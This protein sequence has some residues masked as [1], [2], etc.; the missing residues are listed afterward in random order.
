[1]EAT[2]IG[3]FA[4]CHR[5]QGFPFVLRLSPRAKKMEKT[6]SVSDRG[7]WY[8]KVVTNY[9]K[10]RMDFSEDFQMSCLSNLR[11]ELSFF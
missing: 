10:Q 7:W 5:N 3:H 11:E 9:C 4:I 1:M 6:I 8:K 2:V